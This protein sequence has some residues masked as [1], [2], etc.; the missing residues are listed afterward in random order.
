VS[1]R[2]RGVDSLARMRVADDDASSASMRIWMIVIARTNTVLLVFGAE[3]VRSSRLCGPFVCVIESR[4]SSHVDPVTSIQSRRRRH[5]VTLEMAA[6]PRDP[7]ACQT[8]AYNGDLESL[9]HAHEHGCPW[10]E[11]TCSYAA[12]NGQ[13]GCLKYAH[14]HGCPWNKETC[15]FAADGGHLECLKYAHEQG[16]PLNVVTCMSA[17][18]NGNWSC[19]IY[20]SFHGCRRRMWDDF[21]FVLS[22]NTHVR[23]YCYWIVGRFQHAVFSKCASKMLSLFRRL[24]VLGG[25]R[26]RTVRIRKKATQLMSSIDEDTSILPKGDYAKLCH[27]MRNLHKRLPG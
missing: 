2:A 10:D 12:W 9:K 23:F 15:A 14:E 22:P 3:L 26:S 1:D 19:F 13:L 6:R 25:R 20:A 21:L 18:L 8:A 4:R 7:T 27:D 17:A 5:I 24:P 11:N 16:C